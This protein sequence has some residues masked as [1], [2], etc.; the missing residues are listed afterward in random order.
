MIAAVGDF[1]SK[2]QQGGGGRGRHRPARRI[3][4]VERPFL[5][6][7]PLALC[8]LAGVSLAQN[9]SGWREP[10]GQGDEQDL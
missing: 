1:F 4:I 6:S 9:I 5:T 3:E 10:W 7:R 8:T 2:D